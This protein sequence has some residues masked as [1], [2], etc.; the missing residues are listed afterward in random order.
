M[1]DLMVAMMV[2]LIAG[3]DGSLLYVF[4]AEHRGNIH[5]L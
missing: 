1:V 4:R 2:I 5:E 3:L